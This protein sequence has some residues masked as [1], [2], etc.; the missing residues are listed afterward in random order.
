MQRDEVLLRIDDADYRS[1]LVRSEAALKRAEVELDYAKDEL[2]RTQ[3][4]HDKQL[5]S[6]Q[7]LDNVRRASWVARPTSV[8]AAP[9]GT[10]QRATWNVPS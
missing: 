6:Q 3:S 8:R 5:A 9:P 7:Q 4:L 2:K 10:R 1:A